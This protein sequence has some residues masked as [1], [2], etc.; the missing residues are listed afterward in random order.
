MGLGTGVATSSFLNYIQ[1]ITKKTAVYGNTSLRTS[2]QQVYHC[3]SDL[4]RWRSSGRKWVKF[5]KRVWSVNE[6]EEVAKDK[7]RPS[8]LKQRLIVITLL[9]PSSSI[10]PWPSSCIII[11]TL[12]SPHSVCLSLL[13]Y[14]FTFF[15]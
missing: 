14:R 12:H 6:W 10:S 15:G 3:C 9:T 7:T 13:C 2:R 4:V 8:I 11:G 1:A 5:K